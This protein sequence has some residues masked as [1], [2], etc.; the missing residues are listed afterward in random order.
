MM[1]ILIGMMVIIIMMIIM[2]IMIKKK[3]KNVF[4]NFLSNQDI[5]ISNGD[6]NKWHTPI[7]VNRIS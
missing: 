1:V 2:I 6:Y 4:L 5:L 7:N 3:I